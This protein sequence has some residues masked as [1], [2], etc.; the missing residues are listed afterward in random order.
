MARQIIWT[1]RAQ[2]ERKEILTFWNNRNQT[3][4]YSRKLDELIKDSLRLI[5]KFPSIGKPTNKENVRVK[6]LRN[7]HIIYQ[8]TA[9][10][11]IVLSIG[12][13]RQNSITSTTK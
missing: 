13:N 12:D 3:P 11:I 1:K 6:I 10:E 4:T 5:G 7:Y 2:Q 8:V 9:T